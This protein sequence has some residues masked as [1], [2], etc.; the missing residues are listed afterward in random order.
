MLLPQF[1]LGSA[2]VPGA[3]LPLQVFE[4]RY[5]AMV[6]DLLDEG[7]RF[8]G[9]P[10]GVVLIER[11]HEVGGDDV[12]TDV[13]TAARIVDHRRLPDGR[14]ALITVGTERYRVVRWLDDDPYP[15][16]EVEWWPDDD[17][18]GADLGGRADAVA[19]V[20]RRTWA[21]AAEA[22]H[23]VGPLPTFADG[24]TERSFQL[25]AVAP[26]GPLDRHRLLCAP[27]TAERLDGLEAQLR[28]A[29]EMFELEIQAG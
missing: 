21:L 25:L 12:R 4:P 6:A 27:S 20:L 26:L 11:G 16:A 29:A 14:T 9:S 5:R 19:A 10:F 13:G 3:V 7:G 18:P 22:G 28:D 2:L 23:H 15:L 17:A 24:A 1:P 8:H